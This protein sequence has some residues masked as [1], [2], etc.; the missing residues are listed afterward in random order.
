[1]GSVDTMSRWP[2]EVG[3]IQEL[4]DKYKTAFYQ[5][6]GRDDISDMYAVFSPRLE[7]WIY[8][9]GGQL[10]CIDHDLL[11]FFQPS[12]ASI[13][14][15]K[16]KKN[17]IVY[18]RYKSCLLSSEMD[19]KVCENGWTESF[20]TAYNSTREELYNPVRDFIRGPGRESRKVI[21]E[22]NEK[23]LYMADLNYKLMNAGVN[24]YDRGSGSIAHHYQDAIK[25]R[26]FFGTKT[27]TNGILWI[28]TENELIVLEDIKYGTEIHYIKRSSIENT[29]FYVD[30]NRISIVE[31]NLK[32]GILSFPYTPENEKRIKELLL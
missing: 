32:S 21:A 3:S 17:A 9:R 4:P 18:L 27:T 29:R 13:T 20:A 30:E 12:G 8:R 24:A 1:M 6:T 31:I 2:I 11:H 19:I 7:R 23:Y 5:S 22:R 15:H 10:I 14:Y 16:I 28:M 26:R 25:E